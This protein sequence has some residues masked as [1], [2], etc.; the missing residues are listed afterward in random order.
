MMVPL[1]AQSRWEQLFTTTRNKTSRDRLAA[2]KKTVILLRR[3][4]E[5][6]P[7]TTTTTRTPHSD[8][9]QSRRQYA[10][11]CD[12]DNQTPAAE[13]LT[14]MIRSLRLVGTW[15]SFSLVQL[16]PFT[17]L[18]LISNLASGDKPP[19]LIVEAEPR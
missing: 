15:D 1:R 12:V 4:P 5:E 14:V 19:S 11:C 13:D 8:L 18:G 9:R 6:T 7:A 2:H 17:P 3:F 10:L 16:V